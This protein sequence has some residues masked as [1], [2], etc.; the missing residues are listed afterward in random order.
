MT[1]RSHSKPL[2]HRRALSLTILLAASCL[3]GLSAFVVNQNIF[4]SHDAR[5]HSREQ[6]E[7]RCF[8]SPSRP[9]I[10][11]SSSSPSSTRLYA[12]TPPRRRV[13][14]WIKRV[15][16]GGLVASS[17]PNVAL[18]DGETDIVNNPTPGS[19]IAMEFS[20]LDGVAGKTGT[21]KIQ[22]YPE[23]A[24]KGVERF[25]ELTR[26]GFWN[27]CRIFR[28]LPGFVVQF[29]ISGD[30]LTQAKWRGNNLSDDPVKVSN[31]RGTVTFAT[32]GANTRT[33]QIFIST[34]PQ[35]NA[36]LDKQGFAPIGR[37]IEGMDIVDQCF[38]GYGEGA[39]AGKGPNQGLIQLRGNSYLKDQ[40]PQLSYISKA[41]FV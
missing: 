30:P 13:L 17:V 8:V 35:G 19:V 27:D 26:V 38:A 20:N 22:L 6:L 23:W 4:N 14:E 33:T 16:F 32:A 12:F 37:V 36:F 31:D 11:I 29:G 10:H 40:Y 7:Q 21:V 1:S 28:V 34:R 24:P 2:S 9:T 41:D 39:P 18:A 25:E 3:N 5:T 15:A